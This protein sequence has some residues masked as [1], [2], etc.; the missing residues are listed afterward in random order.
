MTSC[1]TPSD[2]VLAADSTSTPS[3]VALF[4]IAGGPVARVGGPLPFIGGPL[5]IVGDVVALVGGPLPRIEVVLGP[6]QG[7]GASGQPGLGRMERLLGLPGPRLGRPDPGVVDGQGGDPLALR[8]LDDSWARSASLR[9][10]DLACRRSCWNAWSAS[11][12]R[13][14]TRTPLA[15]SIQIRLASA[16]RNW[17][18]SSS[19]LASSTAVET[20]S[21]VTTASAPNAS[22]SPVDHAR[23]RVAYTSRVPTGWSTS[24][25]G[26]LGTP[27]T[28]S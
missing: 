7:G 6:V 21:A 14:T 11:T 28:C 19:R 27:R 10:D 12:P 26:T 17:A 23:G 8:V 9:E 22:T 1:A 3:A 13:V 20:S 4:G 25:T 2:A 24:R 5:A 18:T 15:C 16:C